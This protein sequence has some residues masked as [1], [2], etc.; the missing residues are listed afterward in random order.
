[1]KFIVEIFTDA[2][3]RPEIKV[4]L[5][6]PILIAAVVYGISSHDWVGFAALSGFAV[7][8]LTATT[9]AD[10]QIDKGA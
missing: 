9:I 5:G 1:M 10:A 7:S 2:K 4:I 6:V 8:L 3:G